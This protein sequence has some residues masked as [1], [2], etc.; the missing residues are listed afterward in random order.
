MPLGENCPRSRASWS[1]AEHDTALVRLPWSIQNT[2][3]PHPQRGTAWSERNKSSIFCASVKRKA[4][5]RLGATVWSVSQSVSR[6]SLKTTSQEPAFLGQRRA[7]SVLGSLNPALAVDARPSEISPS[8]RAVVA[9]NGQTVAWTSLGDEKATE[10]GA[11]K[12]VGRAGFRLAT[13]GGVA[14]F[15]AIQI[16]REGPCNIPAIASA[17]LPCTSRRTCRYSP[18]CPP[19]AT[20]PALVDAPNH[21]SYGPAMSRLSRPW[22]PSDASSNGSHLL[23]GRQLHASQ[24][25]PYI[26]II[27]TGCLNISLQ[28]QFVAAEADASALSLRRARF[29]SA[30]LTSQPTYQIYL[31]P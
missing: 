22:R 20:R 7:C 29:C 16:L 2:S 18:A 25:F 30:Y 15:P 12:R 9:E 13:G 10:E 24:R 21:R 4:A 27:E 17:P 3:I 5:R 8:I 19:S 28:D 11:R 14:P 31:P 26:Y 6:S 1:V 23:L